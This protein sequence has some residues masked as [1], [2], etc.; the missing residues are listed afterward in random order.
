MQ[1]LL[2]TS[3]S[4]HRSPEKSGLFSVLSPLD[5]QWG[6]FFITHSLI[7]FYIYKKYKLEL[8]R[9]ILIY[10]FLLLKLY[11]NIQWEVINE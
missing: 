6:F 1:K 8:C 4:N 3:K 5:I 10:T 9:A 11:F 2:K 7:L